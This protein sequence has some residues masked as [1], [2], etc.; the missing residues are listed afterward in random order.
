MRRTEDYVLAL[1]L[2]HL[3]RVPNDRVRACL[4]AAA[5]QGAAL[6]AVA[7][8]EGLL[9]GPEVPA[10]EE[11]ARY[12]VAGDHLR[13]CPK[14]HLQWVGPPGPASACPTCRS[15][16]TR[17]VLP[18]PPALRFDPNLERQIRRLILDHAAR[19]G[20]Q[21]QVRQAKKYQAEGKIAARPEAELAP[22]ERAPQ[23]GK[24]AENRLGHYALLELIGRG[25]SS[26]VYKA[27]DDRDGRTIALKVL[28]L[29]EG[30]SDAVRGEKVARF[31]REAEL[32]S[33]LEHPN[34]VPVSP[35]EQVGPW[36]CI[37]MAWIDGPTLAQLLEARKVADAGGAAGA[38]TPDPRALALSLCEIARGLHFAHC[39]NVIHRDVNPRNILFSSSGQAFLGDFGL[40]RPQ[41]GAEALTRKGVVLGTIAYASLER[42]QSEAEADARSDVYSL[43]VVLY[44]ILTGQL[45]FPESDTVSL[46][47]RIQKGPPAAPRSLRPDVPP[48]LE[49]VALKALERDPSRRFPSALDFA[50]ALSSA[51]A[52]E[53][54][55]A[56]AEPAPPG[57]AGPG[58]GLK[59]AAVLLALAAGIGYLAA[60]TVGGVRSGATA[61]VADALA[62]V[63]AAWTAMCAAVTPAEYG[64]R[65]KAFETRV[66]E[67]ARR[68]GLAAPEV[69]YWR[70]RL[71]WSQGR[72]LE[73][74]AAFTRAAAGEAVP[75]D[76][77]LGRGLALYWLAGRYAGARATAAHAAAAESFQALARQSPAT[78]EGRCAAAMVRV[79]SRQE[80]EA[81]TDL[82][83]LAREFPDRSEPAVQAA[84]ALLQSGRPIES[85]AGVEAAFRRHPFDPYLRLIPALSRL[86]RD[87]AAHVAALVDPMTALWPEMTEAWLIGATA[88]VLQEEFPKALERLD[89]VRTLDPDLL[90]AH[91]LRARALLATGEMRASVDALSRAIEQ[92]AFDRR[93][94]LQRGR[95]HFFLGDRERAAGDLRTYLERFPDAGDAAQVR[96]ALRDA[97]GSGATGPDADAIGIDED[98]DGS[99]DALLFT[100]GL[101]RRFSSGLPGSALGFEADLALGTGV[102][103]DLKI[104]RGRNPGPGSDAGTAG[105]PRDA[106]VNPFLRFETAAGAQDPATEP[107][108]ISDPCGLVNPMGGGG[109]KPPPEGSGGVPE[110]DFA[111]SHAAWGDAVRERAWPF[112]TEVQ[113]FTDPPDRLAAQYAPVRIRPGRG[114]AL[115]FAFRI[116][117]SWRIQ[118][119]AADP[120]DVGRD[121]AC[122][123]HLRS[124]EG[125]FSAPVRIDLH[126]ARLPR[127]V[128]TEGWLAR[129]VEQQGYRVVRG[130]TAKGRGGAVP[131]WLAV[132]GEGEGKT[133][134]RLSAFKDGAILFLLTGRCA[135]ADYPAAAAPLAMAVLSWSR[136]EDAG[137]PH[138]EPLEEWKSPGPIRFLFRHPKS[139]TARAPGR[140]PP[141]SNGTVLAWQ[142][143]GDAQGHLS[144]RAMDRERYAELGAE[145]MAGWMIAEIERDSKATF[146]GESGRGRVSSPRFSG[147]GKWRRLV[148]RRHDRAVELTVVV[149][150]DAAALYGLALF[151]PTRD[152]DP[153]SWWV[154]RRALEVVLQELRQ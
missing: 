86:K 114:E 153:D 65:R 37:P 125:A 40:S 72:T 122:A 140:L 103:E 55:G 73:A 53:E 50:Q 54:A 39:Q 48:A 97:T 134:L 120:K 16:L 41:E 26:Y 137:L 9:P 124:P 21:Q 10:F 64:E 46:I 71:A 128:S 116:P 11:A 67:A 57:A 68:V 87:G 100:T 154:N 1:L 82:D 144:V 44:E 151:G 91:R 149:L 92:D 20:A 83:A 139:W 105:R 146:T 111:R 126:V 96:Q 36:T 59:V 32:A 118:R 115:A 123:A 4:S 18:A 77:R 52:G 43:G 35:L 143:A 70:G 61:G 8:Q 45:P 136:L 130:R 30:D 15:P 27:R 17:G 74:E 25:S 63:E 22:R 69:Q 13:A 79:Y 66:Q 3:R 101:A 104:E 113:D 60:V 34:L 90:D 42:L 112:P 109:G 133:V 76:A 106:E 24:E 23:Q 81:A 29:Q 148:G 145:D 138:A 142:G 93:S 5:N 141:Q 127:E 38:A 147:A 150:E 47:R 121:L 12:L 62:P 49:Q 132:S 108:A 80:A 7:A 56:V 107:A 58:I 6:S 88:L 28:Y 51:V 89:R 95:L 85:A 14:A 78:F 2:S 102:G 99:L 117:A 98:G 119:A 152:V 110:A 129:Y 19:A 31:R 33:R 135:A 94:L 84:A 131:D 75:L